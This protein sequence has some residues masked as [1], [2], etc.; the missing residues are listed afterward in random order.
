MPRLPRSTLIPGCPVHVLQRGHNKAPCFKSEADHVL[1]LGL[2]EQ[3]SKRHA[4]AVHAYVMMTN[5]VHLLISPPDVPSLSNMMRGLNQI[6]AQYVNR[7]QGRCGSAWQSRFKSFPVQSGDYFLTCQGYIELNPVRARLVDAPSQYPWSS[8]LI[9]AAGHPSGLITPHRLYLG[10]APTPG[11]RLAAYR[12]LLNQPVSPEVLAKIR[13]SLATGVP[14]GDDAFVR[15]INQRIGTDRGQSR[16]RPGTG[17][18]L[19]PV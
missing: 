5:H 11:T 14:L 1:Y 18:G 12:K 19:A 10:L 15:G 16:D 13:L 7:H 4:C 2:L 17:P 8:Y 9:N 3:Y 6:F